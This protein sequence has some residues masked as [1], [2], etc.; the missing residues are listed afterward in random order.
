MRADTQTISIRSPADAV[1]AFVADP[2]NL[3]RWAIG[4]AK[5]VKADAD[6]WLVTTGDGEQVSLRPVTDEALGVVDFHMVMPGGVESVAWSRVV[7]RGEGSEFVFTQV[8]V[9]GMPDELFDR[10]VETVEHELTTLKA[11]MEVE[12][13]L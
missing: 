2:V 8:Q 9:P 11:L 1:F 4:F 10:F 13:P 3:S 5:D 6:V 12:C 7:P